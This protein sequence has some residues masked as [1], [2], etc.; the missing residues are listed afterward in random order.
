[1]DKLLEIIDTL[2]AYILYG[3]EEELIKHKSLR[4]MRRELG[5]ENSRFIDKRGK[6]VSSQFA[7]KILQLYRNVE[8]LRELVP[9]HKKEREELLSDEKLRDYLIVRRLPEEQR[10]DHLKFSYE[11]LRQRLSEFSEPEEDFWKRLDKE[12][13]HYRERFRDAKFFGFDEG[14]SHLERFS[15]LMEYDFA[16]LLAIFDPSFSGSS[17][18]VSPSFSAVPSDQVYQELLDLYYIV[19]DMEI[20][21]AL[22]T[23]LEYLLE[24]YNKYSETNINILRESIDHVELLFE[25]HLG[26]PVLRTII[27]CI[28]FDPYMEPKKMEVKSRHI[29]TFLKKWEDRLAQN[30]ERMQQSLLDE[31]LKLRIDKVFEGEPLEQLSPY[32]EEKESLFVEKGFPGFSQRR[33]LSLL[34]TYYLR[35]FNKGFYGSLKKISDEGYFENREFKESFRDFLDKTEA[36]M[37]EIEQFQSSLQGKG[38]MSMDDAVKILGKESFTDTDVAALRRFVRDTNGRAR[39]IVEGNSKNLSRLLYAV[40]RITTDYRAKNPRFVSNLRTIAGER[41]AEVMKKIEEGYAILTTF[42]EV[43]KN[44]AVI[45]EDEQENDPSVKG[46]DGS[47]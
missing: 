34:K 27:A 28:D 45:R 21:A 4:T 20:S 31:K 7:S 16:S 12:F 19:A 10:S 26:E 8:T 47:L 5:Q 15:S 35:R 3:S 39:R 6:R 18:A 25:N 17:V 36:G 24:Y 23:N 43:L 41:S 44:Y 1:M 38:G 46:T 11:V 30:R 42:L 40:D 13:A 37:A 2:I 14:L 9:I 32:D 33:P 29:E 22:R